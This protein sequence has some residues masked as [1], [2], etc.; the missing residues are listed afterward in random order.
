MK[1]TRPAY[2]I[3]N[4]RLCQEQRLLITSPSVALGIIKGS[5]R[6]TRRPWNGLY[7]HQ[8]VETIHE[9]STIQAAF[10]QS[11]VLL[12]PLRASCSQLKTLF[13][14]IVYQNSATFEAS[15]NYS[16]NQI[17]FVVKIRSVRVLKNIIF[18]P[19]RIRL[20]CQWQSL[21]TLMK[22][23]MGLD[24]GVYDQPSQLCWSEYKD[25][26]SSTDFIV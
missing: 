3:V 23:T 1:K 24:Y 4:L 7:N 16:S 25:D 2:K 17:M 9:R 20:E 10:T 22:D 26:T 15:V 6:K 13:I 5:E 14:F 12:F 8:P 18:S 11:G 21:F 19:A